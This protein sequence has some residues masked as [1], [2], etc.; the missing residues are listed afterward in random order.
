ME[1]YGGII[2]NKEQYKQYSFRLKELWKNSSDEN[3][4]ERDVL[5][6]FIETWEN[7][8]LKRKD[9]DPVELIKFLM[10]NHNLNRND[11]IKILGISK[12][13]F[14]KILNYHKGLSKNV[15]RKLSEHFKISQEVFNRPYPIKSEANRGHKDERMMNIPKLLQT[16]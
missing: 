4:E 11:M 6:L 10:E 9:V 13:V 16:A 1:T 15:I 5:E 12:S 14:S 7:E 2:K 8:N 3:E